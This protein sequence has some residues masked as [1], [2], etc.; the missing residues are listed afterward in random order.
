V[1]D[2]CEHTFEGFVSMSIQHL[3][4]EMGLRLLDRFSLL[5]EVSFVAQNRTWDTSAT[6]EADPL[7]RVFS[8]P[9][10]AHGNITLR[11]TRD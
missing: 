7:V 10:P 8:D 2:L 3:V 5:S 1:R 6:S 11:L 4:Y 9:K